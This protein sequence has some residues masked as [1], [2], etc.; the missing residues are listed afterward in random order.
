MEVTTTPFAGLLAIELG[1]HEDARGWLTETYQRE[2]YVAAGITDELVQDNLSSSHRGVLRGLHYQRR[3]PQGKLVHVV[4]GVI[5][6]VAVDLRPGS[7]TFA[8]WFGTTLSAVGRRQLWI[9]PG[10]AHGFLALMD[11]VVAYKCSDRYDPDDSHAI[12]WNDPDL[13]IRWPL[14]VSP[15]LSATDAAAPWFRD[16]RLPEAAP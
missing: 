2:R 14:E 11:A 16:A 6:D 10:F 9:P 1:R 13:A 4:A 15:T 12:R 5:Y 3:R 7:P 8:R